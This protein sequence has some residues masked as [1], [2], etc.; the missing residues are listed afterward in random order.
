M[1]IAASVAVW[2]SLAILNS[3]TAS[4]SPSATHSRVEKKP[5][6]VLATSS[7]PD[8]PSGTPLYVT[9]P[10]CGFYR[11]TVTW[12][13]GS[14]VAVNWI[15]PIEGNVSV[16]LQ[17]NIG[18]P[19]YM[20]APTIP[21]ISQEGYCDSG[22]GVG[23]LQPGHECGRVEF[24]IPEGWE[25]MD[26][27]TIVVMSLEDSNTVGYTDSITIAN[28]NSSSP[29]NVP[30]SEVP[31]GTA[32][33]VLTIPAPTSTNLGASIPYN[34]NLPAPT[35]V[36]R[37]VTSA[38]SASGSRRSSAS[39]SSGSQR[40]SSA[41]SAA[42]SAQSG[43]AGGAAAASASPSATSAA[44]RANIPWVATLGAVFAGAGVLVLLA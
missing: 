22:A 4:P 2:A 27:Y 24:I 17:S 10:A 25:R 14:Q 9:E 37:A 33:S 8:D 3:V 29:S 21:A 13:V 26:N 34:G 32:A 44:I 16:S 31:T 40:A 12:P 30:S 6:A 42:S 18:G 28:V 5:K 20:I 36:T 35:A 43:S 11:C 19:T 15:N 23:V 38:S 39:A 7:N 1:R 41:S